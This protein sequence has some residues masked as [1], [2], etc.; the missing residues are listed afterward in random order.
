MSCSSEDEEEDVINED[1]LNNNN[2]NNILR[3]PTSAKR[4]E[5]RLGL[6]TKKEKVKVF[7]N[8]YF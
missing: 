6:A 3:S 5:G 4:K 8:Y 7:R 2:N 1:V